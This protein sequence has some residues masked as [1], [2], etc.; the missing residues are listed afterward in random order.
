MNYSL[1]L[2]TL[3]MVFAG[4]V[5]TSMLNGTESSA[6]C[7]Q[8]PVPEKMREVIQKLAKEEKKKN[9]QVQNLG[10]RQ[11]SPIHV[12]VYIHIVTRS[13]PGSSNLT[14]ASNQTNPAEIIDKLNHGF[15]SAGISFT[16]AG[17][18]T[19][20][21]EQW[22]VN[23]DGEVQSQM[24]EALHKGSPRDLNLYYVD[25]VGGKPQPVVSG[26]CS[27]PADA[28]LNL[29]LDGCIITEDG[30]R[31]KHGSSTIHE[32]GHWFGLPH[33]FPDRWA[34]DPATSTYTEKPGDGCDEDGDLID[35]TPFESWNASLTLFTCEIGR[36]SCPDKPGVD[37]IHNYMD[38]TTDDCRTEFTP[39]QI[40]RMHGLWKQYRASATI[41][42]PEPSL[43][44]WTGDSN[45]T[46]V[47]EEPQESQS[48]APDE[49]GSQL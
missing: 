41:L 17:V 44:P 13:N 32:V 9:K 16:L 24:Q 10:K 35:D 2:I 27:Y 8:G 36:D 3:W 46:D 14:S 37:P 1:I 31:E 48:A 28:E 33:T 22:A 49:E 21:N 4:A 26:S 5:E 38:Y 23:S 29:K 40:T 19:T 25:L 43:L 34:F 15:S 45:A 6:A 18:D 47:P 39:G 11:E 42:E 12:A 7:K 30:L 20:V